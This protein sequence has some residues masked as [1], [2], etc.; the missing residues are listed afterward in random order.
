[1]LADTIE[2]D[3]G[4]WLD[5]GDAPGLGCRLDEPALARTVTSSP[6]FT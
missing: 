3:G 4:G 1:V 2:V 6:T 5:L